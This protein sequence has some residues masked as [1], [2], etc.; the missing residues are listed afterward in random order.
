MYIWENVDFVPILAIV[1]IA[2]NSIN[3]VEGMDFNLWAVIPPLWAPLIHVFLIP[4]AWFPITSQDW[5]VNSVEQLFPYTIV[6]GKISI[7]T[8][9][10]L[11]FLYPS[12]GHNF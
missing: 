3:E 7:F 5:T 4:K 8:V 2:Q 11:V 12:I 9:Y 10:L 6:S 1:Y